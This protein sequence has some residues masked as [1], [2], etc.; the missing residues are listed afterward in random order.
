M[1]EFV[2]R[3]DLGRS[4]EVRELRRGVAEGFLC[5]VGEGREKMPEEDPFFVHSEFSFSGMA[6]CRPGLSVRGKQPLPWRLVF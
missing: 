1:D 3:A 5:A 2:R 4:T 6:N